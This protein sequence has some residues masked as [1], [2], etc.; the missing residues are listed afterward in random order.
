MG[1]GAVTEIVEGELSAGRGFKPVLRSS[2]LKRLKPL[3]E[4]GLS[5]QSRGKGEA[6]RRG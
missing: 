6:E 2:V 5:G 4:F 1:A 3:G